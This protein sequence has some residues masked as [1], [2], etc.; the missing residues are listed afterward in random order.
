M[1]GDDSL[2]VKVAGLFFTIDA[3]IREIVLPDAGNDNSLLR[4]IEEIGDSK[5]RAVQTEI[6]SA[7]DRLMF[8]FLR[9]F[10]QPFY[11]SEDRALN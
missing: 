6:R 1:F 7:F 3:I 9:V 4:F 8:D 11:F 2:R 5:R 10:D